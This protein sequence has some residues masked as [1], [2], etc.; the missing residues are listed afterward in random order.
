V[1]R[2]F[3]LVWS[4]GGDFASPDGMELWLNKPEAVEVLHNMQDLVYKHHV[5]PTPSQASSLPATDVLLRTGKLA[6]DLN[7]MWKVL[8]YSQYKDLDWSV[9]VLPYFKQPATARFGIP[10]TVSATVKD[11]VSA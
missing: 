9:G 8:D 2:L 1:G 11:P 7:R 10:I 3:P 5:A 6:M 4:N